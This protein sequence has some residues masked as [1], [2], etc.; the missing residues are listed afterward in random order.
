MDRC[1]RK[2]RPSVCAS[3]ILLP[4]G[5]SCSNLRLHRMFSGKGQAERPDGMTP[6][7]DF[8]NLGLDRQQR[9]PV[10]FTRLSV[11]YFTRIDP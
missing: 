7:D 5:H 6:I 8:L 11:A 2:Q 3:F 9:R 10:L 1:D 4:L